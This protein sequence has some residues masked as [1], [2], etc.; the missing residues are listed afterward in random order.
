MRFLFA[1]LLLAS[2]AVASDWDAVTITPQEVR[3]GLT[4]LLGRGGNIAVLDGGLQVDS[5]FAPL[6]PKIA[7]AAKAA[8][9][10]PTTLVNTHWHGDH[11][12]GNEA[13]GTA[14]GTI[15]AHAN[16]LARVSSDQVSGLGGKAIPPAAKAAWP[17][18][19]WTGTHD[20]TFGEHAVQAVSVGPAHTDGDTAV[21][22]V[23]LDA[24]HTGDV[25]FNGFYPFVDARSGGRMVGL[26]AAVDTILARCTDSTVVI[27]GHGPVATT[28]DLQA[29]RAM[30]VGV[31]DA[32][33][34]M[35]KAGKTRDEIVA[36]KPSQPWD[37]AW[38][39]GFLPPDKWV[40]L[41]VDSMTAE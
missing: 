9:V 41:I 16:V 20:F 39:G 34:P 1:L 4:V 26:I 14:G 35:L 24:V 38:G 33:A 22:F 36:A 13:F 29:Y 21:F 5:Q 3:P 10:A 12:G 8:G 15:A 7:A 37:A 28:A 40:G 23:D 25:F 6:A 32:I 31:R 11:T 30:L 18:V 19:T 27:P 17:T 2:P